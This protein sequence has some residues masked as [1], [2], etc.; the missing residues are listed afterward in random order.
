ARRPGRPRRTPRPDRRVGGAG[1]ARRRAGATVHPARRTGVVSPPVARSV[2]RPLGAPRAR[3]D[4][5][6]WSSRAAAVSYP[7]YRRVM[8]ELA[9]AQAR[10]R[11]EFKAAMD[12]YDTECAARTNATA[13]ARGAV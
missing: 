13:A 9:Q 10:R 8:R 6:L 2:L 5:P 7:E 1:R 12:W 11:V 4:H 3:G